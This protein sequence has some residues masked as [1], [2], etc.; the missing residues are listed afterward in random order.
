MVDFTA[1]VVSQTAAKA[2]VKPVAEA[3]KVEEVEE[4]K[5]DAPEVTE[6]EA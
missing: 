1:E 3:P 5:K 4:V 2:D 6:T